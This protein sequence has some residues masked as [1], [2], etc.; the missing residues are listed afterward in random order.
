MASYRRP[1]LLRRCLDGVLAQERL[2]DRIVV[3]ARDDDVETQSV[4]RADGSGLVHLA[5]VTRPGVVAAMRA[6]TAAST[7]DVVAFTD[8]DAVPRPDWLG[9]V[10]AQFEDPYVGGV[11]GRDVI[12]GQEGPLRTVVGRLP[13]SGRLVGNHHLGTGT[14][15]EVDVL[16]GV[17]MAWRAGALAFPRP[18]ILRGAGMQL[19]FELLMARWAQLEGWRLVY[20]PTIVVDHDGAARPDDSRDRPRP[21]TVNAEAYN[22][23][24]AITAL[25][26][27]HRWLRVANAL[28]AGSRDTPGVARGVA[29]A[30]RREAG[31]LRRVRPSMAGQLAAARDAAR[32]E[33]VM[34]SA[35]DLRAGA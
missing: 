33:D 3:A 4:V 9:R 34:T 14:A 13:R 18:E 6:G 26:P 2:P 25:D 8:D 30:V 32:C 27:R 12:P 10:V 35:L 7:G 17:N 16:K 28:L 29:A 19:H 5:L 22:L 21:E 1:A 15:R 24:F 11:G 20:D 31:V 23:L